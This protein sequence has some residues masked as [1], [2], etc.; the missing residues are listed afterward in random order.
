MPLIDRK[1]ADA[2]LTESVGSV[3]S[4]FGRRAVELVLGLNQ[5][6]GEYQIE[7]DLPA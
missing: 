6:L 5:W 7:L 4:E 3:S 1:Q 2:I